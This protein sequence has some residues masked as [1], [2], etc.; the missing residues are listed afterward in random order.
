MDP[1]RGDG[2]A[3]GFDF[4]ALFPNSNRPRNLCGHRHSGDQSL[5]ASF[6]LSLDGRKIA[7]VASG[8]GTSTSAQPLPGIEGA[9]NPFW[10]PDNR[11]LGFFA[12][13]KLKRIDLAGGQPQNLA[14]V[15]GTG[16]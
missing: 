6:A 12:D 16:T 4:D 11:S 13:L 14:A 8:E 9:L 1:L 7:F 15:Q 2:A 3:R 10:S 5:P